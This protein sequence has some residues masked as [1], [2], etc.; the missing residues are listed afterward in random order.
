M[1]YLIIVGVL[2][3]SLAAVVVAPSCTFRTVSPFSGKE[4]TAEELAAEKAAADANAKADAAE[5]QIQADAE[6]TKAATLRAKARAAFDAAM[7]RVQAQAAIQLDDLTAEYQAAQSD[8]DQAAAAIAADIRRK[9]ERLAA[10]DAAKD[11]EYRAALA[12]IEAKQDRVSN[13]LTAGQSIASGFGPGGVA[14]S[15]ILALAGGIFGIK[16]SRD[17]AATEQAATRVVDAIDAAKLA[18]PAFKAAFKNPDTAKMLSE[19][20]GP[21]G[22]AL[23]NRAQNS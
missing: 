23:V 17:A 6:A 21:A 1:R 4:V 18:D 16:K 12:S 10:S 14:I 5:L 19:W 15:S 2:L 20:M 3:V 13:L 8:A 11:A 22:V 7:K 9:A